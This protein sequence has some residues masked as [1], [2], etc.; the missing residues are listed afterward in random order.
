MN[1]KELKPGNITPTSGQYQ[2]IGPRG[3]KGTE[4]TSTKGHPLPP[5]SI[6][7]STYRLVDATKHKSK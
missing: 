3:G 6:P 1:K 4:V 2:R 5:T 7:N